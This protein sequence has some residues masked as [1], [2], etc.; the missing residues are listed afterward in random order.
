MGVRVRQKKKGRGNPWWVFIT[1]KGK[2]TSRQIGDKAAAEAVASKVRAKLQLDQFEW[3]PEKP[4]TQKPLF[5]DVAK[6]WIEITVP[7]TCKESTS[8][9]YK[10]IL[11]NHVL[12]VFEDMAIDEINSG[13]IKNFLFSKVN[14]GLSAS[15]IGHLKNVVSGVLTT[16]LDDELI[17]TNP[18][19]SLGKKFM[20]KIADSIESRKVSNGEEGEGEPD[21]LS[22][23]ELKLL[24]DTVI[25]HY[26]KHY[27]LFLFLARTGCRIGE[28]LG[29]KWGDIDFNSRFIN[30]SRSYSRGRLSTLKSKRTRQ[31]DMSKQLTN[32]VQAYRAE[33]KK[34]GLALGMSEEPEHVFTDTIGGPIDVNNW[35]RRTYNKALEKAKLRKI[36]IHDLR[37]TYATLR[38]SKGD[39]MA[40]VSHQLGHHS[41]KFTLDFY[42]SW[43]PGKKK[44]EV[45]ALDDPEYLEVDETEKETR[46]YAKAA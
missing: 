16:A 42:Y 36:R 1:H 30:L 43:M 23:K 25:K 9:D 45:D 44:G 15:T 14:E 18:A 22:R 29:L 24:L 19:L 4:V 8:D 31:V 34:K 35:R 46:D 37:H 20:K 27:P 41:V 39:S 2:R 3:E 33:C 28:A 17:A 26:P 21:P 5:K 40:D 6:D 11:E 7:A 12:P 13:T 10:K 38:I 32:T